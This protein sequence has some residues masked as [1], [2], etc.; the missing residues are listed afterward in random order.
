MDERELKLNSLSR[1]SKSSPM[2]VLE[3]YGHCEIP[4]GCG[5]VVLRW[6][7]PRE[8][9]P[10]QMSLYRN[11]DGETFLDGEPPSSSMPLV[12]FG[13]HMLAF[14]VTLADPAYM[15]LAFAALFPSRFAATRRT[16]P[17]EPQVSVL[18]AADGTWKFTSREP[19]DDTWK[20]TGFDDSSW[21]PMAA[22]EELQ[23]PEDP[24][25]D[26]ARYRF[27]AVQRQGGTGLGIPEPAARIW[28]RKPFE[29]RGGGAD[30]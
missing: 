6:R 10:L 2:Y 7:N 23:P 24:D 25:R 21:S 17:D 30:A 28:I 22:N 3:E 12:P 13:E 19:A 15:V 5:G 8:G 29:L 16:G 11:G 9:V 26:M 18:S 4:A 14:E 27:Q 20:R 1:Y